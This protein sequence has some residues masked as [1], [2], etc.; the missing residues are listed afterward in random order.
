MYKSATRAQRLGAEGLRSPGRLRH[1][2]AF[3]LAGATAEV[4]AVWPALMRPGEAKG[5]TLTHESFL[6]GGAS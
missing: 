5:N 1:D 4:G 3:K 6:V 2:Q